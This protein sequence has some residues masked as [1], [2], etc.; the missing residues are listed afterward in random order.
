MTSRLT[1]PFFSATSEPA[2]LG[3]GFTLLLS[4]LAAALCWPAWRA[5]LLTLPVALA[6]AVFVLCIAPHAGWLLPGPA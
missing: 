4:M 1:T 5:R 2:R 3:R 6:C